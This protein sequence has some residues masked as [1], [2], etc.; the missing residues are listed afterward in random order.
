MADTVILLGEGGGVFYGPHR[1]SMI[2]ALDDL[3]IINCLSIKVSIP[4]MYFVLYI[5]FVL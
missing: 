3:Y 1:Y 2:I 4:I 5:Y